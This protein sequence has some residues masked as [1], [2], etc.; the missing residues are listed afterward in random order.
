MNLFSLENKTILI[1]GASSGIGAKAAEVIAKQG[2]KVVLTAR[3]EESLKKLIAKLP[4]QEHKYIKADLTNNLDIEKIVNEMDNLD[5]IVNSAGIV[6]PFPVKFID[7][8]HIDKMFNINFN[9]PVLL[10]SKLLRAQKLNSNASVVFM[11][12]ISSKFSHKGG[13]LYSS[14]KSAINMYSKTIALE[15][16]TNRIRSNVICA[17]MVKTKMFDEAANTVSKEMM[18]KHGGDYPLGFGYPIDIANAIVFLLSDASRWIT[19]T[20]LIM[21]GGLSIGS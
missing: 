8:E 3:N 1:S 12:S 13:A 7:Q 14:S 15:H 5:G 10:T 18:E 11:S 2:A 4:G 16:A 6:N 9:A 17:A 20:E 21:D 19:G